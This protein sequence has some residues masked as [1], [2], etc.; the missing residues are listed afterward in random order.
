MIN[1]NG[2]NSTIESQKLSKWNK[3]IYYPLVCCLKEPHFK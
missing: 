3:Y 2:L 1:T